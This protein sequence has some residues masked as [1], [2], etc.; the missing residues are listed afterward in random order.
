MDLSGSNN[1]VATEVEAC[2]IAYGQRHAHTITAAI[3]GMPT[4][5]KYNNAAGALRGQVA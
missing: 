3:G 4:I 5:Y 1:N 2:V